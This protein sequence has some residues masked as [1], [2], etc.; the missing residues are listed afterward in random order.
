MKEQN[1]GF[2]EWL[3]QAMNEQGV[4][5]N[6]LAEL[7][8]VSEGAISRW[9]NGDSLPN[10]GRMRELARIFQVD[11]LQLMSLANIPGIR[12]SGVPPLGFFSNQQH[13]DNIRDEMGSL[14][15]M[16]DH[17]REAM[18]NAYERYLLEQEIMM[19]PVHETASLLRKHRQHDDIH[20]GSA[21]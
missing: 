8:D 5:G 7:L 17:E 13:Q 11:L 2:S 10:N 9:R 14:G 3:E 19:R 6:D 16:N 20:G 18:L 4:Q 15:T 1:R 12:E 21:T